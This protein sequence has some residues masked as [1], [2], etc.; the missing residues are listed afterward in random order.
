MAELLNDNWG[1]EGDGEDVDTGYTGVPPHVL[2]WFDGMDF[3]ERDER[4]GIKS[5]KLVDPL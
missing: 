3:V 5:W 2:H 1:P 4:L